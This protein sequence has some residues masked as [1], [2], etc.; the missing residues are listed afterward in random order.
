MQLTEAQKQVYMETAK[1]LDRRECRLFMARVVRTF[2]NGGQRLAERELGWNRGTIRAGL[3]ELLNKKSKKSQS[4]SSPGRKPIEVR[5]PNL[6][7]DIEK[8]MEALNRQ[9]PVYMVT[10]YYS[11]VT[12]STVRRCLIERFDYEEEELPVN[13]TLRRRIRKLGYRYSSS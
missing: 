8:I 4:T 6:S 9:D 11:G 1:L 3:K 10:E 2:G 13:E 7:R 5:L 12:V